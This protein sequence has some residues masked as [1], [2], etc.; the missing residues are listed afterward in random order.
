M[1]LSFPL[2]HPPP[3]FQSPQSHLRPHISLPPV[4]TP[5]LPPLRP[6]P[7]R[8]PVTLSR[9]IVIHADYLSDLIVL[10]LLSDIRT[11]THPF[12]VL[13]LASLTLPPA[14]LL[15]DALHAWRCRSGFTIL[16]T[17]MPGRQWLGG[18]PESCAV[19]ALPLVIMAGACEAWKGPMA[20][21]AETFIVMLLSALALGPVVGKGW[22]GNKFK[23][24]G[25]WGRWDNTQT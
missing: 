8:F 24:I 9:L 20:V 11:L 14:L 3:F 10:D 22:L 25:V 23:E 18:L 4:I 19:A 6:T 16:P 2:F 7:P 1:R 17:N 5:R 21:V 12:P 15:A 13:L